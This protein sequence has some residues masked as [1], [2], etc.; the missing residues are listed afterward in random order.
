M[1]TDDQE[2]V[3]HLLSISFGG[4]PAVVDR[5]MHRG[6]IDEWRVVVQDGEVAGT[7]LRVP[8]GMWFHGRSVS[9]LGIAGV[10]TDPVHRGRGAAATLMR[11]ILREAR[12]AGI[13][14][15]TLYPS[16]RELYRSVGYELAGDHFEVA[17]RLDS[18]PRRSASGTVARW[19]P[20]DRADIHALQRNVA[21]T[22]HGWLDRGPYVWARV[23]APNMKPAEGYV[24]RHDGRIEGYVFLQIPQEGIFYDVSVSDW[25]AVTPRAVDELMAFLA[26]FRSVGERVRYTGGTADLITA[27]LP[28]RRCDVRLEEPFML[29]IIDP[30]RALIDRGYDAAVTAELS[31]AV[32]A[33]ESLPENIA[34]YRV[35]VRNGRAEV[36][37][38]TAPAD[39][40]GEIRALAALYA[41]YLPARR[42]AAIGWIR[43]TEA[44]LRSA[45]SVFGIQRPCVPEMF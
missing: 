36:T 8:M 5:W 38:T 31:I 19:S 26:R 35:R 20:G 34:S 41:G 24:I 30:L 18:L 37:K 23:E 33:D 40:Q 12:E 3:R 2:R 6:G 16:T 42:L 9:N 7:A 4:P 29:R 44:G 21:R 25:C 10:A 17:V 45:E 27:Q 43:G 13:A 14:L 39:V 22:Q 1:R 15:S 28:A 11:D 32:T